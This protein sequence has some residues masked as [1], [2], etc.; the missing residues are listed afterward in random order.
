MIDVPIARGKTLDHIGLERGVDRKRLWFIPEPD[1]FYRKRILKSMG[2]QF[3]GEGMNIFH[4][5]YVEL[6]RGE[7]QDNL[8][9]GLGGHTQYVSGE[10]EYMT[11]KVIVTLFG[12][13]FDWYFRTRTY[14]ED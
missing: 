14:K 8:W 1:M 6:W 10:T 12:H 3:I 13:Q 9:F 2:Y 11:Y 5:R 4:T 7:N